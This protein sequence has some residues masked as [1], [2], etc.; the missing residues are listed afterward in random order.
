LTTAVGIVLITG[1]SW[2]AARSPARV[3]VEAPQA[4]SAEAAA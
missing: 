2:L 4:R 1:G 3:P